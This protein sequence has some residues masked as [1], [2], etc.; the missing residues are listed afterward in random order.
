MA[1]DRYKINGREIW[2]PDKD[3]SEAWE[4]TY[5]EDSSRSQTGKG[6]FTPMF[7]TWQ[8]QYSASNIPISEV[9][10]MIN[11]ISTGKPFTLHTWSPRHGAWKDLKC[12]VGKSSDCTIGSLKEDEEIYKSFAFNATEVDAV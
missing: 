4:T 9:T 6:K 3:I 7:T 5:T 11:V 12:Y 8:H 2:Q 10:W 1:Q